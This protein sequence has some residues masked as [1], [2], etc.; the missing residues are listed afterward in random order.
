MPFLDQKAP[1]SLGRSSHDRT[2]PRLGRDSHTLSGDLTLGP[3]CELLSLT[4]RGPFQ[5]PVLPPILCSP[6]SSLSLEKSSTSQRSRVSSENAFFEPCWAEPPAAGPRP[7]RLE[8]ALGFHP[9]FPRDRCPPAH[10]LSHPKL[11]PDV[12]SFPLSYEVI[13]CFSISL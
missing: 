1:C 12:L 13:L 9:S 5:C 3:Q 11:I 10:Y 7:R 6:A 8:S 4:L 2:S